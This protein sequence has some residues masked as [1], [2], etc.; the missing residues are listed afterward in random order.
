MRTPGRAAGELARAQEWIDR[1]AAQPSLSDVRA[2]IG[3]ALD[4]LVHARAAIALLEADRAAVARQ[5]TIR[6]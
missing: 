3:R 6:G 4:M 2:E 5:A 1:H